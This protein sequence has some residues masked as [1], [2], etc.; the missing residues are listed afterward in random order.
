LRAHRNPDSERGSW[1]N[2]AKK[3]HHK[4]GVS[5]CVKKLLSAAT[6]LLGSS[7]Y[8]AKPYLPQYREVKWFEDGERVELP[9]AFQDEASLR[10]D[11]LEDITLNA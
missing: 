9:D 2:P 5:R 7:N 3:G 6:L 11:P 4:L 8:R 10:A 1:R